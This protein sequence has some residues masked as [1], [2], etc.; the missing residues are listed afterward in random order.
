MLDDARIDP[1]IPVVDMKRARRF[2]HD[3]LGLKELDLPDP[4]FADDNA[5]FQIGDCT[6]MLLYKRAERTKAE[7]TAAVFTV[8][9]VEQTVD[10]LTNRG[11]RFEQYDLPGIKTDK[12]GIARSN[13]MKGAWFKDSEGNILGVTEI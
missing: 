4:R 12:R 3:T 6:R 7:H 1:T 9:D 8:D 11:V 10:E 13:G 2:Y 5:Y